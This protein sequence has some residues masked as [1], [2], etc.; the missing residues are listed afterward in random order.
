MH[1]EFL[2]TAEQRKIK[3]IQYIT[4]KKWTYISKSS[5]QQIS[6]CIK[7]TPATIYKDLLDLTTDYTVFQQIDDTFYTKQTLESAI[8][9]IYFN[10][11]FAR[12]IELIFYQEIQQS[13]ELAQRLDISPATLSQ[14]IKR[15]NKSLESMYQIQVDAR[16]CLFIGKEIHIRS[17]L[18]N[19][20]YD[21]Q[22]TTDWPFNH[23]DKTTMT[24]FHQKITP[25]IEN[26]TNVQNQN[27]FHIQM[28][29]NIQRVHH[30]HMLFPQ[31]M[32]HKD[33]LPFE[34][35]STLIKD[36]LN[37][38]FNRLEILD[39]FSIFQ[40][41]NYFR[42]QTYIKTNASEDFQYL[43]QDIED[44]FDIQAIN[45]Q[46]LIFTFNH[47][48][49]HILITPTFPSSHLQSQQK[50][51]SLYETQFPAFYKY[52]SNGFVSYWDQLHKQT[53]KP[54]ILQQ[55]IFHLITH[56]EQLYSQLNSS[57]PK[58]KILFI[59]NYSKIYAQSYADFLKD[60]LPKQ[61][62]IDIFDPM[63]QLLQQSALNPYDM[64]LSQVS[65]NHLVH[66]Y[67][68]YISEI[69][70]HTDYQHS[71]DIITEILSNLRQQAPKDLRNYT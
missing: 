10:S 28:S 50:L 71:L 55:L 11:P 31:Q 54:I 35:I 53:I 19:F 52:I 39:I 33:V 40:L 38:S 12:F 15:I 61:V 56:W 45:R 3:I 43:I 27:A 64:I 49:N 65:L 36:S 68:L 4:H 18:F 9:G 25:I 67:I 42:N 6:K 58:I 21:K 44:T 66:P 32:I 69:Y 62:S 34:V 23:F 2:S 17:F 29:I 5:I 47:I 7:T 46:D 48:F 59:P 63:T 30:G 1:T 57:Y 16:K 24:H 51:L 14:F 60:Q 70:G 13:K 22:Q 20:F 37:Y 41:T 8:Y 26:F